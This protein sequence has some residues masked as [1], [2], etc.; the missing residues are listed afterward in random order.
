[1]ETLLQTIMRRDILTENE[2][3]E[4]INEVREIMQDAIDQGNFM[5]AEEIFQSELGIEPDYIMDLYY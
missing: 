1:M 5:E 4:V 3:N 2:A